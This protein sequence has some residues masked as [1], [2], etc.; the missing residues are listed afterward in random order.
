MDL[1]KDTELAMLLG[2]KGRTAAMLFYG[3][4][5][6]SVDLDF[7]LLDTNSSSSIDQKKVFNRI[8]SLFTHKYRITDHCLKYNTLFWMISYGKFLAQIKIKISTRDSS[9]NQYQ[10]VPF[11]GIPVKVM[12]VEDLIVHKLIALRARKN[13]ANRDLFDIHYFFSSPYVG[14]INYQLIKKITGTDPS[15]FFVQLYE[16]V[17]SIPPGSVLAGL[18]EVLSEAQKKWAKAKLVLEL[19]GLIQLQIDLLSQYDST[20]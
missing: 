20:F 9:Y 14:D 8:T 19:K 15:T 4:P 2:F 7:D 17:S 18:G 6:F 1:Y 10:V 5:G 12:V 16:F 11:Y 13:M 3:L